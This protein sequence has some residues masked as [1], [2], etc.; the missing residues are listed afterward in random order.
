MFIAVI[1]ALEL[2][3]TRECGLY[4]ASDLLLGDHLCEKSDTVKW[5]DISMPHK[6]NR[7]LK[8][9]KM[10]QEIAKENPHTENIFE[11]NLIDTY[12]PQR[13][14]NLEALCLYDF[15]ANYDWYGKDD[16]GNRK[17]K[18]LTKSRLPN[19][20]LFDPEK[21]YEREDY[22]YSLILFFVPFRDESNLLLQDESTKEAFHR[23]LPAN[24][25][26]SAYHDKLQKML[27]AQSNI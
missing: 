1:G 14:I 22:Y 18:K 10:L 7:R 5:I 23:L 21:E 24:A 25:H 4:E 19:H 16:S 3:N 17:Y 6:R 13:P 26:C 27:K 9:H 20:K 8:D 2:W 12:Y 11:D 15:V